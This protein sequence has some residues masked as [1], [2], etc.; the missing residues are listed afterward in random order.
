MSTGSQEITEAEKLAQIEAAIASPEF[1][2]ARAGD[3]C[4]RDTIWVYHR[5]P[6]SPSGVTLA[7]GGDKSIVEP[8]LRARKNTSPLSPTEREVRS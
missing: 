3:G 5:N 4:W 2:H 6:D 1:S 8:L 7:V